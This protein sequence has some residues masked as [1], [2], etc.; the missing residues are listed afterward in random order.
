HWWLARFAYRWF[1]RRRLHRSASTTCH[2][3]RRHKHSC[4]S[5]Y[6]RPK[7]FCHHPRNP[8]SSSCV[9]LSLA[10]EPSGELDCHPSIIGSPRILQRL[11]ATPKSVAFSMG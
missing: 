9:L 10:P 6:Y 5:F 1:A 2:Q 3:Q 11:S 8:L 4:T 7:R